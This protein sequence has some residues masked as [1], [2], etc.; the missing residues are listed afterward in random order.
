MFGNKMCGA[1]FASYERDNHALRFVKNS[2][3]SWSPS[4][5]DQRPEH[6]GPV[7][8]CFSLCVRLAKQNPAGT[9]VRR[10]FY[11]VLPDDLLS[12]RSCR[13]L[14]HASGHAPTLPSHSTG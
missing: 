12:L 2:L 10:G 5:L 3:P 7:L 14:N 1:V 13:A 9:T 11:I 8:G 6:P 4:P